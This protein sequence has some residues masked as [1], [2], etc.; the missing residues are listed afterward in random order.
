M[1]A[2]RKHFIVR[3][4]PPDSRVPAGMGVVVGD[5]HIVTCAHVVNAA[6]GRDPRNPADPGSAVTVKVEFLLQEDSAPV[7]VNCRVDSWSAPP[8]SGVAGGDIAGLVTI[9][10]PIPPEARPA[11]MLDSVAKWNMPA[12]I[13]GHPQES[14]RRRPAGGWARVLIAGAV[15]GGLIQLDAVSGGAFHAQPGYSGSP[16]VIADAAG[17]AVVGI[18]SA[19]ASPEAKPGIRTRFLFRTS[20][21]SGPR[22]LGPQPPRPPRPSTAGC[23]PSRS[24]RCPTTSSLG[25]NCSPRFRKHCCNRAPYGPA[26]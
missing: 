17:D 6:L 15:G 13:F 1:F 18:L 8:R 4:C 21:A 7:P 5:R 3:I 10:G 22:C 12:S 16:V 14:G 19:A 25:R 11:R 20:S 24:G 9:D 23:Q 2:S 26:D